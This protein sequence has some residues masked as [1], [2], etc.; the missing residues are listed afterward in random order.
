MWFC[1]LLN[2]KMQIKLLLLDNMVH[3]DATDV[4]I[5]ASTERYNGHDY[6]DEYGITLYSIPAVERNNPVKRTFVPAACSKETLP[7]SDG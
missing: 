4:N 7:S 3:Q 5:A 1:L 6:G 2:E